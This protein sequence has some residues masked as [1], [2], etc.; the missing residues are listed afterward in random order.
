M[1]MQHVATAHWVRNR[2]VLMVGCVWPR[3][4]GSARDCQSKH[5]G[6]YV[7]VC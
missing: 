7:S 5:N 3:A 4:N 2:A 1:G 6:V